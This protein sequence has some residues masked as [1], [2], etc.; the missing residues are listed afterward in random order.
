MFGFF[1]RAEVLEQTA[2]GWLFDAFAWCLEQFDAE[3][4]YRDTLLVQPNN[5]FFP[6]RADSEFGMA[7]LIFERVKQY[8]GLSH[9]PT[10]LADFNTCSLMPSLP[11]EIK[12]ALRGPEG[13][14]H[15]NL[16]AEGRMLIPYNPQQ[17][18]NPEGMIASFAHVLSHHLGQMASQP[19]PGGKEYWPHATELLAIFLGFGLMFA[20]SAFTYKG[21]CGSCYNPYAVRSAYL[22]E[23]EATYALGIF[24][25]LKGISNGDVTRHLKGHLR[26]VYRQSVREI[27]RRE[28]DLG[29][30]RGIHTRVPEL[31]QQST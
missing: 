2:S 3:L 13:I 29:R 14:T 11:V 20:N 10:R 26:G 28:P 25:V 22:S 30:L 5:E 7:S 15:D 21:G 9:W 8:A 12:G 24:A 6:G 18:G 31:V 1:N 19:P 27:K 23:R 17:I 16:P 4:F